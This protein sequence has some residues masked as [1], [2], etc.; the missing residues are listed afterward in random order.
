MEETINLKQLGKQLKRGIGWFI[1]LTISGAIIGGI[2]AYLILTPQYTSQ[3]QLIVKVSDT[4]NGGK[5]SAG[6]A[7]I[8][9]YKDFVTSDAVVDEVRQALAENENLSLSR[10]EVKESLDVEQNPSS[11]MFTIEAT[12]ADQNQ[13]AEI[14]N[15]TVDVFKRKIRDV[16]EVK[17]IKTISKAIP[18][19]QAS[20]PNHLLIIA[21]GTLLGLFIGF[22]VAAFKGKK[23]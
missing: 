23:E 16:L 15:T 17:D 9:T 8:N 14:A 20:F 4:T 3:S 10:R 18:A 21:I 12:A 6:L 11:Q 19:N 22:I 2:V 7:M 1:G 5:I 13:A